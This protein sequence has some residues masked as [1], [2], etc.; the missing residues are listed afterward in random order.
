MVDVAIPV[1]VDAV[2]IM[3]IP[4]TT[5]MVLFR[6][7]FF[8]I[9]MSKFLYSGA[10][11]PKTCRVFYFLA[12]LFLGDLGADGPLGE[13]CFQIGNAITARAADLDYRQAVAA[14]DGPNRKGLRLQFQKFRRLFPGQ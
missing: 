14:I 1:G 8:I 5:I 4:T 13:P 9:C 10:A 12:G 11:E 6:Q 7:E 2:K 3:T